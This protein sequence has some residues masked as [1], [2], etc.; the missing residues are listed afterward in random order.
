MSTKS[1][2]RDIKSSGTLSISDGSA[3]PLWTVDDVSSYLRLKPETVRLMARQ[4]KIPSIKIGRVW[5]FRSLEIKS[6]LQR[7]GEAG[8]QAGNVS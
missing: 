5:R 3:E 8:E 2:H 7:R 6:W 4:S 1:S